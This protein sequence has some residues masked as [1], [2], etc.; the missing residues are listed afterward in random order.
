MA[1]GHCAQ[2]RS[3]AAGRRSARR[4]HRLEPLDHVRR[5]E[6]PLHLACRVDVPATMLRLLTKAH[7]LLL[8]ESRVAGLQKLL[9]S[10][11]TLHLQTGCAE[12]SSTSAV[13]RR[14]AIV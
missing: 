13:N 5:E 2:V 4:A 14:F 10:C 9:P 8:Q 12:A 1:Q 11:E 6:R 3:H 7:V